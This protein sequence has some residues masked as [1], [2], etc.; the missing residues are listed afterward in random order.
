MLDFFPL[1]PWVRRKSKKTTKRKKIDPVFVGI[2][3]RSPPPQKK[4]THHYRLVRCVGGAVERI[5]SAA[6]NSNF[7]PRSLKRTRLIGA[8]KSDGEMGLD[9]AGLDGAGWRGVE[10][11][12]PPCKAI[13]FDRLPQLVGHIVLIG[14]V[15]ARFNAAT[16]YGGR[17][18]T[19]AHTH[20]H[21]H[22]HTHG[23]HE[24]AMI[25]SLVFFS[26]LLPCVCVCVCFQ[27]FFVEQPFMWVFRVLPE[28][29]AS[30]IRHVFFQ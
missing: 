26:V 4:N 29:L 3:K 19:R 18:N 11:Q 28:D 12:P 24:A 22:T 14:R 13:H 6:R 27:H 20:T 21:T 16:A 1:S 23:A 5:S 2:R 10:N 7:G 25:T 17:S 8:M 30:D 15:R 9:E